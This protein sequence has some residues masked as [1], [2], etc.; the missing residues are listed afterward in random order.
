MPTS[1]VVVVIVVVLLLLLKCTVLEELILRECRGIK[2][3]HNSEGT[4]KVK[5]VLSQNANDL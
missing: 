2:G 1:V 5:I 4:G 3:L